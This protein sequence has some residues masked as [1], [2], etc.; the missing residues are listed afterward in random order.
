M[1]IPSNGEYGV[2]KGLIYSYPVTCSG[3]KYS[4][5][6]GL[7]INEYYQGKIDKTTAELVEEREAVSGLLK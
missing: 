1:A 2:P 5:V 4:I 3:G 6:Q 7:K